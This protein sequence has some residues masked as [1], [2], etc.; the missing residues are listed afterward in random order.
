MAEPKKTR[1][2]ARKTTER[3]PTRKT[4]PQVTKTQAITHEHVAERA[5]YL[6][7]ERGGDAFENWVQAERELAR[8]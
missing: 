7:L 6:S 5:Y 4:K 1:T 3:K 8:A 2:T